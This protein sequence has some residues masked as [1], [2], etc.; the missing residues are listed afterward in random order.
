[1]DNSLHW[2]TP[3]HHTETSSDLCINLDPATPF[4]DGPEHDK[5]MSLK[6]EIDQIQTVQ[7]WDTAKKLTNPYEYIFLSLQKRTHRS[8]AACIPLSRSYFKMVEIWRLLGLKPTEPFLT[9]HSA[10]GPGGFLEAILHCIQP[11]KVKAKMIAMT[12]RSTEKT[13]PGWRKSQQFLNANPTVLVTYGADGTGNLYSL[14]NQEDYVRTAKTHLGDLADLYTADGGF[15][16]SADFNAQE[17]TVQRLLAA[18]GLCGLQSLKPGGTMI[19]KIFDTTYAG[20]LDL[21]WLLSGCFEKTALTKPLTSR[22]ANSERY[23]IGHRLQT[24][25]VWVIETLKTLTALDAPAGWS[26]IFKDLEYPQQWLEETKAFQASV[27]GQ[28]I[29][30]IQITLNVIRKPT[31]TM[32]YSLLLSNIEESLT[33]CHKH[34]IPINPQYQ[35]LTVEKIAALN[36]EEALE[37]FQA[38][39]ARTNLLG[40]SRPSPTPRVLSSSPALPPPTG[41]AWRTALPASILGRSPSQTALDTQLSQQSEPPQSLP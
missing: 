34:A 36:L 22:P 9:S 41:L 32:I 13:I 15:D 35:G 17:N 33:W 5:L 25:P 38:S 20:T 40:L 37:P 31:K 30:N 16:F 1:M 14:E 21:L 4:F 11:T 26:R 8:I 3:F 39:V 23:W 24:I 7:T 27:E 12:L 10:E 6:D 29:K 18:E 2:L 28:Q 19:L